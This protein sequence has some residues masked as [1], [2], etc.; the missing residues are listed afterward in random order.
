M[1][2]NRKYLGQNWMRQFVC[3]RHQNH[4][5]LNLPQRTNNSEGWTNKKQRNI[6]E[7]S[8]ENSKSNNAPPPKKRQDLE[9]KKKRF[10][11]THKDKN[12]PLSHPVSSALLR[13]N[14]LLGIL[15]W[16]NLSLSLSPP[17]LSF[18]VR[19]CSLYNPRSRV[20]TLFATIQNK[21]VCVIQFCIFSYL[22]F[23]L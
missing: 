22:G 18:W 19:G 15:H 13:A 20:S 11:N 9:K 7:V 17:P 8:T 10:N 12:K 14:S 1:N 21:S 23:Q 4:Y 3:W 16:N 2:Y 5:I 6:S